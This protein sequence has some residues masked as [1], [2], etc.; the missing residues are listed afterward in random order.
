MNIPRSIYV[1]L[2]FCIQKCH[3]CIFPVHFLGHSPNSS[4]LSSYINTIK[5]EIS[6]T[7]EKY[8]HSPKNAPLETLYFGGGTPSL[9]SAK[10]LNLI[11]S[12]IKKK[13]EINDK[14]EISIEMNPGTF[15]RQSIM[16]Y[17]ELGVNRFSV[18]VQ[19][20]NEKVLKLLNRGHEFKKIL[21]SIE[22]LK[23]VQNSHNFSISWDLLINLPYET[24]PQ[25]QMLDALKFIKKYE[26]EHLSIYSLILEPE[27]VFYQKMGFRDEVFPMP[28]QDF[29]AEQFEFVHEETKK[30][31]YIHYEISSFARSPNFFCRHNEIYWEGDH[32]FLAFGMGATSLIDGQRVSRPT[33]LK[34]YQ[35]YVENLIKGK[36][37][38][39]KGVKIEDER[40]NENVKI[41][42]MGGLRT[43]K[44]VNLSR[45]SMEIRETLEDFASKNIDL[46]EINKGWLKV[47]G[48]RGF[49]LCDEILARI[50][51]EIE[52]NI[53][54]CSS[55]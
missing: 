44:G 46:L 35:E 7:F 12:L 28:S 23:S 16:D 41:I 17:L 1:H 32:P 51:V 4:L 15:S 25:C 22:T 36:E 54:F 49:L 9:F 27:S 55:L 53:K 34:K 42:L 47:R 48:V 10:D 14:T 20:F 52:K 43:E 3:Y 29:G 8:P 19:S 11:I 18:G 5:S 40:G 45:F 30:A 6:H 37:G 50:F 33:N 13:F 38:V 24:N 26:P 2:P 21:E 39:S 31:G